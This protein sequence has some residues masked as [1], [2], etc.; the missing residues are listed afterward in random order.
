MKPIAVYCITR[1]RLDYTKK[2]FKLLRRMA[3]MP[4][5]LY[6]F[7]N[8]SSLEMR[9]W[10]MDQEVA[11]HIHYL[12]LSNENL[13][14]N[15]AANELLDE[16]ACK[17]A[18]H[19]D[20]I[21]RWDNDAIPRTRDFMRK[22]VSRANKLREALAKEGNF[23]GCI[24]APKITKLKHPQEAFMEGNDIGFDYEV[25]RILGGICRLHPARWLLGLRFDRFAALGFGEANE[26]ARRALEDNIPKIRIPEIEVE[27]SGGEDRQMEELPEEFTFE[28]REVVRHIGYGL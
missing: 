22:L 27:H 18:G 9:N 23:K 4:F 25:V 20:W 1:D 21:M 16:I 8:G 28:R 24:V 6:V 15:L 26:V 5:D 13:G 10:L 3:G 7:D 2:S 11:G 17:E 19:Y 12:E 14:Q